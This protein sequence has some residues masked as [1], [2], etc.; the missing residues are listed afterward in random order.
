MTMAAPTNFQA[1]NQVA[2]MLRQHFLDRLRSVACVDDHKWHADCPLHP[3]SINRKLRVVETR[4]HVYVVCEDGCSRV[5]VL[6]ALGIA[7]DDPLAAVQWG[8]PKRPPPPPRPM[9]PDTVMTPLPSGNI[10]DLWWATDLVDEILRDVHDVDSLIAACELLP[11]R[12]SYLVEA[13]LHR[14]FTTMPLTAADEARVDSLELGI[15]PGHP[16]CGIRTVYMENAHEHRAFHFGSVPLFWGATVRSGRAVYRE[17]NSLIRCHGLRFSIE[18]NNHADFGGLTMERLVSEWALASG[19]SH[20]RALRALVNMTT[21]INLSADRRLISTGL[22]EEMFELAN[23]L[24]GNNPR[25]AL[26]LFRC[27]QR[28]KIYQ[29]SG[30]VQWVAKWLRGPSASRDAITGGPSF[31]DVPDI[32]HTH[33]LRKV[34]GHQAGVSAARYEV[35]VK[36]EPGYVDDRR[37]ALRLGLQLDSQGRVV[38]SGRG[39]P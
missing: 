31:P 24:S 19:V 22:S 21:Q 37:A 33:I 6:G 30:Q 10:Y 14:A 16:L 1:F 3:G 4:R 27:L 17:A 15:H 8:D 35:M 5:N 26:L 18:Y 2:A 29:S 11:N 23:N 34:R 7:A 9:F 25:K 13:V 20:H 36:I 38:K 32:L 12:Q 28:I 39:R